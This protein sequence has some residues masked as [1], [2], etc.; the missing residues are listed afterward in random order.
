M[1]WYAR[2][3]LAGAMLIVSSGALLGQGHAPAAGADTTRLVWA[4]RLLTAMHARDALLA[5]LDSGFAQEQRS[6]TQQIPAVF[7]DSLMAHARRDVPQLVDSLAV[8]WSV[9]MSVEDLQNVVQFYEGPLGQRYA[10]AEAS[11]TLQTSELAKRWG[12]REAIAVMKDL[13]D[14]GL[15]QD[16]PH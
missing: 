5:G 9:Q 10:A 11:V 6:S 1:K 12:M 14:K 13:M 16:L 8:A 15:L 3:G 2:G 4:R 7:F